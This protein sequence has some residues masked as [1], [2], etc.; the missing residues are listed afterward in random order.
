[1]ASLAIRLVPVPAISADP[2]C[3]ATASYPMSDEC[4]QAAAIPKKVAEMT[5]LDSHFAENPD[6]WEQFRDRSAD[7]LH[8]ARY[9]KAAYVA[10]T[11]EQRTRRYAETRT[12]S[13]DA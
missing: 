7:L 5:D 2:M 1:M 12:T 11:D 10:W 6:F 13:D 8:Q 3:I 4:E 9:D